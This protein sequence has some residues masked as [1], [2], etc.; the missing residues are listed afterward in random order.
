MKLA[1]Q[2]KLLNRIANS[3]AE[4]EMKKLQREIKNQKYM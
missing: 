1:Q 3:N 2:N 4:L